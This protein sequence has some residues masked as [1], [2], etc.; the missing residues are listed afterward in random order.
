MEKLLVMSNIS[1]S[2]NVFINFPP[3]GHLIKGLVVMGKFANI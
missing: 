1:I 2:Y 3:Q